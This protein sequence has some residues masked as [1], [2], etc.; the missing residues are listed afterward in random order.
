MLAMLPLGWD[1][2]P[3]TSLDTVEGASVRRE[4]ELEAAA[5]LV[6]RDRASMRAYRLETWAE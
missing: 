1:G 4:Q 2:R 3:R 5:A 6:A